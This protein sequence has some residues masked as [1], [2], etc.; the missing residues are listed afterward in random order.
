MFPEPLGKTPI[1][2]NVQNL[3]WNAELDFNSTST[4]Q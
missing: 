2:Q 4:K 1:W 3:N